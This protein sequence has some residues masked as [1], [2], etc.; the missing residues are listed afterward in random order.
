MSIGVKAS[1][2]REHASALTL[3]IVQ[4]HL[5]T[6]L[7]VPDGHCWRTWHLRLATNSCPSLQERRTVTGCRPW[8]IFSKWLIG[9]LTFL[10]PSKYSHAFLLPF[11]SQTHNCGW[12]CVFKKKWKSEYVSGSLFQERG[13]NVLR[14]GLIWVTQSGLYCFYSVNKA[15]KVVQQHSAWKKS[16]QTLHQW[17]IS[18]EAWSETGV[19]IWQTTH[20]WCLKPA[21]Q[22]SITNTEP[23][24]EISLSVPSTVH[25]L[26][27]CCFLHKASNL[28]SRHNCRC[29]LSFK[30]PSSSLRSVRRRLPHWSAC[31]FD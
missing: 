5:A 19:K 10:P 18:G 9:I 28:S 25:Y 3:T 23:H 8:H 12:P 6:D 7:P 14:R 29:K 22:T 21:F 15:W 20:F 1:A 30:A 16:I 2:P 17:V 27:L 11:R 31:G 26:G 13:I 24:R 4:F